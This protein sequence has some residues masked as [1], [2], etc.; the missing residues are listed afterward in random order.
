MPIINFLKDLNKFRRKPVD[1]GNKSSQ[2]IPCQ[3]LLS[4]KKILDKI[5]TENIIPFWYPGVIDF[6]EGG[7]RL[8]HGFQGK[9]KGR[10]NKS[11]VAQART[12]WFFSRLTNSEY[13]SGDYLEAAVHGYEFLR[14]R[15]WDKQFGGFF[16]EVDSTG[17]FPTKPAKHLYGQAFVL[18]ALSEFAL[19]SKISSAEKLA[20]ELFHLLEI[21]LRRG[22]EMLRKW[23]IFLKKVLR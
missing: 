18:Y 23:K 15:M 19:A 13:G 12:I 4:H 11:L 6:E 3:D 9:W 20:Q 5:L 16:W 17:K 8:N 10:A 7:Y 2:S 21:K 1:Q 14:N 22:Q